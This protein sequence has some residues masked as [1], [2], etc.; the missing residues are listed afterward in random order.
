MKILVTGSNGQLGSE[1]R[2]L[3]EKSTDEFIFT[4]QSDLDIAD[5]KQIKSYFK[6][7]RFD[8][9]LNC[10][11][12]TAVDK[13]EDEEDL[14][15]RINHLGLKYLVEAC[16]TY[17]IKLIHFST[18]YVFNGVN[19]K[20]YTEI[21]EVSP[22]SIYG[23]SKFA[24]EREMLKADISGL[25]IRT[26]WLYSKFGQNFV[27]SMLKLGESRDHLNVVFDQIGTP[28]NAA[29]LAK[30]TLK[31]LSMTDKWKKGVE[32]YH[33]SNE[34][35]ASWYDFASEIFEKHKLDCHVTPILSKEYPTK[36]KRPH[37]SVLDKSKFKMD[38][39]HEIR[40]WKQAL[41]D[42]DFNS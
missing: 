15:Y 1:F 31:C 9:I 25:V 16:K 26:S 6:K 23:K 29:D 14:A 41:K 30:A 36:A 20:P 18:D 42:L 11:A 8:V 19:H 33:F 2:E 22:E 28:T 17:H 13:A 7:H 21:D 3:S 27:K 10:A 4:T 40:H 32:I 24:G 39:D 37:F 38:F 35:V 12:Y 34:G 5:Q